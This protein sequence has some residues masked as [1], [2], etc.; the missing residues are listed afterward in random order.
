V[1]YIRTPVKGDRK[2]FRREGDTGIGEEEME[3]REEGIRK[4]RKRK[5]KEREGTGI[6][7]GKRWSGART[8]LLNRA[9]HLLL[10]RW[11]LGVSA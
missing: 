11:I 5:G 2:G 8:V 7:E 10:Q 3:I 6:L 4:E 9:P 1:G